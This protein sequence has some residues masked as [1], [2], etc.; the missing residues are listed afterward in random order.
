MTRTLLSGAT[1]VD[2]TGAAP[3]AADIVIEDGLIVAVGS[4][5]DGDESLDLSG[6]AVLPGLF[7]CHVHV[8]FSGVDFL[9]EL[10]T[11][12]SLPYYLAVQNLELTLAAGITTV[13]D[14]GGADAG[15][16][17][18]VEQGLISGPRIRASITILSQT[19]GHADPWC[20]SGGSFAAYDAVPGRPSSVVDGVEGM[21]LRV[22]EL[23]RAGADCI[24]LCTSGGVLSPTD[25]WRHPQFS[26]AELD[27][28]VAEAAA[29]G[30]HVLAHAQAAEGIKN[31]VRA[32]I[33]SIEH[34]VQLDDE[35]IELML[36]HG[37]WLV[38]TL[39]APLSVLEA[40][41]S[42]VKIPDA[43]LDKAR[44]VVEIHRDSFRRAVDA[45]VKVAMGTD[46]GVGPHGR[47]LRE[48]GLMAEGGMAP[49]DVI[50][51]TT[52]SAAQLL[53][54]DDQLGT[55]EVGKRAD[56]VVISGDPL[57]VATIGDRVEQ[58]WKDG[59]REA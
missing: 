16:R 1:V 8:M 26:P 24:K 9:K 20:P 42:G 10:F 52:S 7:D 23:V 33:R 32:G 40:S 27:V 45:G 37:T 49:L 46:S 58:V 6:K 55:L 2:G 3:A 50:T 59:E 30:I 11:P 36:Q 41:D 56:L 25:S 35:A 39:V 34:G 38:P 13:R 54:L 5:L 44:E 19:G 29:A 28:A 48:L 31:A 47:N 53:G 22:R 12:F 4:G 17:E 14:A 51:A 57:D 43:I 15:V 21:R 18:A